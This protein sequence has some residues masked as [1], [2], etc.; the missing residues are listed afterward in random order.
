MSSET[1]IIYTLKENHRCDKI[2]AQQ[3][4]NTTEH[5]VQDQD[6]L[7]DIDYMIRD[8]VLLIKVYIVYS[9]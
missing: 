1:P 5:E 4:H 8:C 2:V 7:E 6:S 3:E 9:F